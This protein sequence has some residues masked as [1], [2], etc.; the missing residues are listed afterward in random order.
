MPVLP[1]L[2]DIERVYFIGGKMLPLWLAIP[3]IFV[4]MIVG[5]VV[6]FLTAYV[7]AVILEKVGF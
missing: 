5:G 4:A 1:V 7:I 2:L 3:I 6:L